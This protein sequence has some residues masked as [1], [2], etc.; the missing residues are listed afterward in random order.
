[1][2]PEDLPNCGCPDPVTPIP[3][4]PAP[5]TCLGGEPCA[6]VTNTTCVN[7]DGPDI[8]DIANNGDNMTDVIQ[9]LA[10]NAGGAGNFTL[11]PIDSTI[12]LNASSGPVI[13]DQPGQVVTI[14]A[15]GAIGPQGPAGE[16]LSA[17]GVEATYADILSEHPSPAVLDAYI[18]QDTGTFWVY[19]PAS[20]A[21]NIDGWVDMGQIQGPTGPAGIQ[22]P[23]GNLIL[24]GSINPPP[25]TGNVGDYWLN[26]ATNVLYGPQQLSGWPVTGISLVG[27]AGAAGATGATGPAG[28]TGATGAA[29]AAGAAGANG[30]NGSKIYSG[31]TTPSAGIGAVGDF[32]LNTTTYTLIG[33]KT[34]GGWPGTG[35]LLKGADGAAGPTGATGPAGANGSDGVDGGAQILGFVN[36][37]SSSNNTISGTMTTNMLLVNT[38]PASVTIN[39]PSL[40][41]TVFPVGMQVIIAWDA[42]DNDPPATTVSFL[43][44]A[45]SSI[46]SANGML[47]LRTRYSTAT[48]IKLS[49]TAGNTVWYL[50]GDLMP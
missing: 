37:L 23:P 4:A 27:P 39:V 35:L 14:S 7:Y 33:P 40:D 18:T 50:A 13:V 34:S 10:N 28:A 20:T 26:T 3:T 41:N 19:D 45:N 8:P 46:R 12:Q 24:S 32:Y 15:A 30:T 49:Y 1:M 47:K 25:G 44:G 16:T 36:V 22:G 21:A 9:A 17:L 6:E 5:P 48:L 31:S 2:Y 29:G 38:G 11:L 42:W 43:A